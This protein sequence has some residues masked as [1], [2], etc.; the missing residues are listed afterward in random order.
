MDYGIPQ[1]QSVQQVNQVAARG[2]SILRFEVDDADCVENAASVFAVEDGYGVFD[3]TPMSGELYVSSP[4]DFE[5]R[6]LY[7]ITVSARN[8]AGGPTSYRSVL[9]HVKDSNDERP[10]F[11]GGTPVQFSVYENLPGP[12]PAVIGSTISEDL[13]DGE[14]GLIA[15]S[16]IKGNA[17]LFSINSASGELLVLGPL[18]REDCAEHFLTVQAID[19][20]LPRL[21]STADIKITVIDDNDNEPVF[22]QPYYSVHVRENTKIGQKVLQIRARDK[23]QG[24]NAVIRYSLQENSPFSIDKGTGDIRVSKAVDR[25]VINEYRLTIQATDSGRYANYTT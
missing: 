10:R 16:I 24:Q 1:L 12:F 18:D 21:S 17:T 15:Y 6:P 13:D 4:L 3:V 8:I 22:D 23:D 11:I 14:N 2:T 9:V 7:N 25:E 5:Y 20:G 19:S